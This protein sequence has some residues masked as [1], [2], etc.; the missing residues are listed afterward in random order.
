MNVYENINVLKILIQNF[1]KAF[2]MLYIY[3]Y[4][5]ILIFNTFRNK[6][7]FNL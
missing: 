4:Y 7:N 6:I 3:I 2:Y 1:N 5:I